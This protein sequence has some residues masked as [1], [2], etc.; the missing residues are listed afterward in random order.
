LREDEDKMMNAILA[1]NLQKIDS[2]M[3]VIIMIN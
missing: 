3:W 2:F 1:D